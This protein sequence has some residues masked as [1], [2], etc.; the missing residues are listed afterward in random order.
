MLGLA[1]NSIFTNINIFVVET[2]FKKLEKKYCK[3]RYGLYLTFDEASE[4]C[5]SE[6]NCKYIYDTECNKKN[7]FNLCDKNAS[8]ETSFSSCIYEKTSKSS[9]ITGNNNI[10]F[11]Y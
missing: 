2:V 10:S 9:K 8:V 6:D 3:P 1:P 11:E 4:A 7:K 5:V